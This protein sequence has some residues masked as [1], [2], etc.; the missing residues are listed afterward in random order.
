MKV[1]PKHI[2]YNWS[3]TKEHALFLLNAAH[4]NEYSPPIIFILKQ[5]DLSYDIIGAILIRFQC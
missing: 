2:H 5:S 3:M 1:P 4:S